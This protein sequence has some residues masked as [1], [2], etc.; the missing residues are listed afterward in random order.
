MIAPL[1]A[2]NRGFSKN[3]MSSIGCDVCSSQ[4]K[5]EA[6]R[7]APR[8]NPTMIVGEVQPWLG[9]SMID[10]SS[11]PSAAM[12]STAPCGSRAAWVGS[13]DSGMKRKPR[14]SPTMT[15]GMFTMNTD[16][17][18]KCSS[19]MPPVIGPSPMPS[20][21][22]PAHTP[23]AL[24]RSAASVNTFVMIDSVAGMMNAPPTPIRPRVRISALALGANA[25]SAEPMPNTAS[26]KARKRYRPKRSPRLPAVS[27][28][29][30]NTS[31]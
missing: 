2:L 27:S 17:H 12:D 15:I 14:T 28:S 23:I 18:Q 9:A 7:M 5:K 4:A 19:R 22:T 1:A 25:D 3:R 31:T 11:A 30:A 13:L 20:A 16:P 21:D 24:R 8:T 26:P 10:H 6:R 29:P